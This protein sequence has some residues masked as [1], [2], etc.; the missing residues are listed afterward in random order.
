MAYSYNRS[1]LSYV[2]A[3][4]QPMNRL[5]TQ[6]TMTQIA[7]PIRPQ[8][9]YVHSDSKLDNGHVASWTSQKGMHDKTGASVS[10]FSAQNGHE[11]AIHAVQHNNSDDKVAGIIID[12]AAEP[13]TSYYTNKNGMHINHNVANNTQYIHRMGTSGSVLLA[14]ISLSDHKNALSGMYEEFHNGV[15]VGK[16]V[17]R[18]LGSKYFTIDSL[19]TSEDLAAKI[20]QL[21]DRLDALTSG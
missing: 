8:S 9:L 18:E 3:Y 20:E 5:P 16:A 21:E 15:S 12:T 14:W 7:D 2:S 6:S 4:V 1:G 10:N 19:H 17:V 11:Y 13:G